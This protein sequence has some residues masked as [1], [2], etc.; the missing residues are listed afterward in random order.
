MK[1]SPISSVHFVNSP[2]SIGSR[3]KD[4]DS[5]EPS[6]VRILSKIRCT[7][8]TR[9]RL[10]VTED[11]AQSAS[12]VIQGIDEVARANSIRWQVSRDGFAKSLGGRLGVEAESLADRILLV[13]SG[14]VA[15]IPIL[16][17]GGHSDIPGTTNIRV[18]HESAASLA[19]G[20]LQSLGHSRI[21]F[22]EE[23]GCP[24]TNSLRWEG[25]CFA[26]GRL[27]L[28][29]RPERVITLGA[30]LSS[31]EAWRL[32]VGEL[33]A[34][35]HDFT[36]IYCLNDFAALGAIAAL[37]DAGLECPRDVSVVG[38]GQLDQTAGGAS[39]LTTT[40]GPLRRMGSLAAQI[41][42]MKTRFPEMKHSSAIVLQPKLILRAST[43]RAMQ[44][45][46]HTAQLSYRPDPLTSA[47][48]AN[49]EFHG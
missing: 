34:R 16:T 30:D 1:I 36:A 24:S 45:K 18:D 28:A 42:L 2:L 10:I 11:G 33:V 23:G 20:H 32:A 9:L 31:P 43:G 46:K 41:L 22:L 49:H 40:C 4:A 26:A 3:D 17:I 35:T 13:S 8:G 5:V 6:A 25:I 37:K 7:S 14:D 47:R 27:G 39:M 48:F 15:R 21:A 12:Q 38:G 44:P 19:L 29:I